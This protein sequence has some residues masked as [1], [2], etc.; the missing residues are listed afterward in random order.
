M[1]VTKICDF[2]AGP[3]V[4]SASDHT[5]ADIIVMR[6]LCIIKDDGVFDLY[7]MT[8]MTVVS[9][10]RSRPKISIWTD[11]GVFTDN[12][13]TFDVCSGFDDGSFSKNQLTFTIT[14]SSI[15]PPSSLEMVSRRCSFAVSISQG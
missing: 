7:G 11:N 8:D 6:D 14:F 12:T 1:I 13:G 15:V 9:N 5:V 4:T 2:Y 3:E 10:R